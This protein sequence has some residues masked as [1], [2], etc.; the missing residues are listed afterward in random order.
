MGTMGTYRG[1]M[2][3]SDITGTA[4]TELER[5]MIIRHLWDLWDMDSE[6]FQSDI[7]ESENGP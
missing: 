2:G 5:P 1:Q 7:P 4:R 6:V 3:H